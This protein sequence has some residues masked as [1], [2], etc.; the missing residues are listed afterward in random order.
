MRPDGAAGLIVRAVLAG[1][2]RAARQGR[3]YFGEIVIGTTSIAVPAISGDVRLEVNVP[4]PL[5]F[6]CRSTPNVFDSPVSGD[7]ERDDE[8]LRREA[9]DG[10]AGAA[11]LVLG[12]DDERLA[13]RVARQRA[14]VVGEGDVLGAVGPEPHLEVPLGVRAED[15][16]TPLDDG[17]AVHP[18]G[19]A[20]AR[21]PGAPVP[22]R[23]A[24]NGARTL[25]GRA[26]LG[27]TMLQ[28]LLSSVA[29]LP[30]TTM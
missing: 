8:V 9:G 22:S 17:P 20:V 16:L 19:E 10:R 18:V 23:S 26:G 11:V 6:A 3:D 4:A 25:F 21:I 15:V 1:R 12:A 24:Q 14:R 30:P 28:Q 29:P 27:S 5:R 2:P 13:E 7:V